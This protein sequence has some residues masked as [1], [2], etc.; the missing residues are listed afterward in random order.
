EVTYESENRR[1]VV[2]YDAVTGDRLSPI[3]EVTAT[4]LARRDFAGDADVTSIEK[5]ESTGSHSEYRNKELPAYRVTLDHA[6]NPSIYIS[7]NRGTVTTRRNNQ[8]RLFDFFWMLHTMDYQGRDNFNH[9]LLKGMSVF[10]MATV[11]SGF[12]LWVKTSRLFRGSR[13]RSRG[14]DAL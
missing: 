8:W 2:L 12:G 4:E 1:E 9:W 5:I 3:D 14:G 10:G 13:K 7:A 6:T 11:L